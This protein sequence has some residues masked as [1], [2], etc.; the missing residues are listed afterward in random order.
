[1]T[2]LTLR[3][4]T[5]CVLLLLSA[6]TY[7]Q[8]RPPGPPELEAND[9]VMSEFSLWANQ[10]QRFFNQ[11]GKN[12][13]V[14]SA[15]GTLG[16]TDPSSAMY[17]ESV[18]MAY[19]Q[20]MIS[21]YKEIAVKTAENGLNSSTE[22]SIDIRSSRGNAMDG[23]YKEQC[24]EE[25]KVRYALYLKDVK[26]QEEDAGSIFSL[27]AN[28]L[29]DDETL[30]KQKNE[31]EKPQ[32]D[33]VHTCEYEGAKFEQTEE[34]IQSI[35]DILSGGRVW[36]S[37]IHNNQLGI[38]LMR[39]SE[40]AAVASVLKNQVSPASV[41]ANAL[42]ELSK[43]VIK[44]LNKYPDFPQSL[45]GTRMKRLSNGEWAIYGYGATQTT[46]SS[47]DFMAGLGAINDADQ[48][49]ANSLAELTR[50]SELNIDFSRLATSVRDVKQTK[51]VEVNM[52]KDTVRL[53]TRQ[54]NIVGSIVDTSF[55][56]SSQLNLVGAE[57]I[58]LDKKTV[59]GMSFYL[60]AYAWSPSIM[61][62]NQGIRRSQNSAAEQAAFS[63]GIT[64]PDKDKGANKKSRIVINDEDW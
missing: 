33:F 64:A 20:A 51:V 38:I 9:D 40:T 53:T 55:N 32:A 25:A 26:E 3:K 48:A 6:N 23:K 8:E 31:A 17:I 49:T 24:R 42:D 37:V 13:T 43:Q 46:V 57:Q 62:M 27:L 60:S 35:S 39:S 29:K 4:L 2:S 41:N 21:G 50:F 15:V 7:S 58:Y 12:Y 28:K 10:L 63:Q 19:R 36:A 30:A 34:Q 11:Q 44:D 61:G 56:A 22:S 18:N 45:V 5:L 1:M 47:D 16:N 54:D 52:S 14:V 59:D